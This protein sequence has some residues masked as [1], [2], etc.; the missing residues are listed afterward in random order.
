MIPVPKT[1]E[2]ILMVA[3][4]RQRWSPRQR[5]IAL[6]TAL[7]RVNILRARGDISPAK[8]GELRGVVAPALA[9]S[10][11]R[12]KKLTGED[13]PRANA[14]RPAGSNVSVAARKLADELG[15]DLATVTGTGMAGRILK[16]DVEAHGS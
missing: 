13:E 12:L 11:Q 6:R 2:D 10:K 7:K 4:Q 3:R 5:V 16:R 14:P 1:P 8:A 9:Q 15:I